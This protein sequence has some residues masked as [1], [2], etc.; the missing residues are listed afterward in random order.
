MKGIVR[1][2]GRVAKIKIR[3]TVKNMPASAEVK[4]TDAMIQPGSSVSGWLPHT[5][6]LPWSAKVGA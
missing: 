2:Q 4:V 6:E 3:V 1:P 5:T